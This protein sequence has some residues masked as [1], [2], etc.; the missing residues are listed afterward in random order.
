MTP[1]ESQNM[2]ILIEA[3]KGRNL[4]SFKYD[5]E[6][7]IVEPYLVGELYSI[8]QNHLEE[9]KYALRA[10]F[11]RGYSSQSVDRKEGDRWRKYELN[12]INEPDIL[13]EANK[14]IMPLYNKYDKDFKR[15][16]FHVSENAKQ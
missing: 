13:P 9:R 10:W 8:H 11:V 16:N 7:R 6:I 3:I 5:R 2:N 12:K 4:I 15:I 1:K 14:S